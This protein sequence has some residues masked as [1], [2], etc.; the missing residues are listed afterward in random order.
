MIVTMNEN[1]NI[2]EVVTLLKVFVA[3]LVPKVFNFDCIVI[4]KFFVTSSPLSFFYYS[5]AN[6]SCF[7]FLVEVKA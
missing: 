5:K 2:I 3:L 1:H 6:F 4:V 7:K